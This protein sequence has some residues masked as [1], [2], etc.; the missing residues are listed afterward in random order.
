MPTIS[1]SRP[2]FGEISMIALLRRLVACNAVMLLASI[3]LADQPA[4]PPA[5]WGTAAQRDEI[6]PTFSFDSKGGPGGHGA[7]V[8]STGDSIGQ[9]GQFQKSFPVTGGKFY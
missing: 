9:N 2:F 3:A 7:F 4:L 8:I 1:P 6:R 5:G